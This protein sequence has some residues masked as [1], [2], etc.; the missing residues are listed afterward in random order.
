MTSSALKFFLIIA[1]FFGTTSHAVSWRDCENWLRSLPVAFSEW[2]ERAKTRS[3][4]KRLRKELSIQLGVRLNDREYSR[5][6]ANHW[7]QV[8]DKYRRLS[9]N[10]ETSSQ[11]RFLYEFIYLVAEYTSFLHTLAR[12]DAPDN[13]YE[14]GNELKRFLQEGMDVDLE[15]SQETFLP[16][17][18]EMAMEVVERR[19]PF[20]RY[21]AGF[22]RDAEPALRLLDQHNREQLFWLLEYNL[23]LERDQNLLS[24]L[25]L[26]ENS[27]FTL[28]ELIE[29][30]DVQREIATLEHLQAYADHIAIASNTDQEAIAG[31]RK[32]YEKMASVKRETIHRYI[33][34]MTL[35]R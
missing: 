7:N 35:R 16:S 17:S 14:I 15:E 6:A 31:V 30:M 3:L 8:A 26:L 32:V 29:I 5:L 13:D 18:G 28:F 25:N 4:I 22:L 12:Y 21:Y 1:I 23:T 24:R 10:P 34:A 27:P 19:R 11:A 9:F 20:T 33:W 2:R